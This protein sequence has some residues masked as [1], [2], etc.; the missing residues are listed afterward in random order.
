MTSFQH[1]GCG[2][3]SKAGYFEAVPVEMDR[4]NIVAGIAH[5]QSIP[6][7]LLQVKCGW[8]WLAGHGIRHAI[9]RPAVEAFLRSVVF[10]ECHLEQMAEM[11]RSTQ[12]VWKFGMNLS[13]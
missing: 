8:R 7:A 6:L 4:M 3:S 10:R 5:P 11:A 9:D 1:S 13:A 12:N 2:F